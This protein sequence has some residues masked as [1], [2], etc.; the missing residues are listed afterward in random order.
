M[1]TF[2]SKITKYGQ[3][4]E[5]LFCGTAACAAGHGPHAGIEK[6]SLEYWREYIQRAFCLRSNSWS[7]CFD[8]EWADIDNTPEGAAKRILYLLFS[9]EEDKLIRS[10]DKSSDTVATYS[11]IKLA[12]KECSQLKHADWIIENGEVGQIVHVEDIQDFN[13]QD[14][15]LKIFVSGPRLAMYEP[16]QLIHIITL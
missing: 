15:L 4:G 7:W 12:E 3:S 14:S 9:G 8:A 5:V 16:T 10:E 1:C 11:K 6:D 2:E 13:G